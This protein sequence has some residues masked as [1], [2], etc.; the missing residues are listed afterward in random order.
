LFFNSPQ[1]VSLIHLNWF[2]KVSEAENIVDG[3]LRK[4][5]QH[6]SAARVGTD[7]ENVDVNLSQLV[8]NVS[9]KISSLLFVPS[10]MLVASHAKLVISA[11]LNKIACISESIT[12]DASSVRH[13]DRQKLS[14]LA[15]SVCQGAEC[16]SVTG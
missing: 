7:K 10:G 8:S 13:L 3:L 6:K 5:S 1:D 2:L 16:E 14:Q 9:A 11:F 12:L 4:L 15:W